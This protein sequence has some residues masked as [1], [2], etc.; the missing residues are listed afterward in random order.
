M[1]DGKSSEWLKGFWWFLS[2][3]VVAYITANTMPNGRN[4]L[5][6]ILGVFGISSTWTSANTGAT[7]YVANLIAIML[8]IFS[9]MRINVHWDRYKERFKDISQKIYCIPHITIAVA[10]VLSNFILSPSTIDQVYFHAMSRREGVAAAAV[11]G[12]SESFYNRNKWK[13]L[14][15]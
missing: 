12:W 14:H 10:I 1:F 5:H 6:G 3:V 11:N 15:I 8:I 4:L 9:L 2:A 13:Y 7:T